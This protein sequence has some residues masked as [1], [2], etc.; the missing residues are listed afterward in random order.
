VSSSISED[1][2][3][4]SHSTQQMLSSSN[5]VKQSSTS[6]SGLAEQLNQMVARFTFA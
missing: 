2:T 1:I 4:V 5:T 3:G 6:L